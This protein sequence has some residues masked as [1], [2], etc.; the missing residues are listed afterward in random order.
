MRYRGHVLAALFVATFG[1]TGIPAS[2]V[3]QQKPP[4]AVAPQKAATPYVLRQEHVTVQGRLKE[5]ARQPGAVGVAAKKVLAIMLPHDQREEE[6]VFPLLGLVSD[7]AAGKVGPDLAWAVAMADRVKAEQKQLYI[8]H[9]GIISAL[10]ELAA[11]ARAKH[12]AN[13]EAFAEA[14][15][16]SE[17]NDGEVEYPT[18]IL[19]GMY[20][21]AQLPAAK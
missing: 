14:V 21:R 10:N 9:S 18:A 15:A 17:V 16:A 13:L 3:A 1:V 2:A 19:V 12:D 20:V 5:L 8:E 7:L 6:F 4:V 11:A